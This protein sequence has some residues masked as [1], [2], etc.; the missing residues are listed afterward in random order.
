VE[1]VQRP[2]PAA[3]DATLVGSDRHHSR[4]NATLLYD[5]EHND[6]VVSESIQV[7]KAQTSRDKGTVVALYRIATFGPCDDNTGD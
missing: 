7:Q 3:I 5:D 1:I 4:P 6:S 2:I